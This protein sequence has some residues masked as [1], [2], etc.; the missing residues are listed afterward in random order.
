MTARRVEAEVCG[1]RPLTVNRVADLHRQQWARH[2]RVTREAWAWAWIDA[3]PP[4]FAGP[5]AEAVVDV[6]PLHAD[7][8]SPQDVAACAPEAKAAVDGAVDAGLILDDGPAHVRLVV[9]HPPD[10]CGR[11]GLRVTITE[12]SST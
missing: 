12:S 7:G 11:N 8:R 9:F 6:T 2:T 1:E 5:F 10:V 4:R 3:R